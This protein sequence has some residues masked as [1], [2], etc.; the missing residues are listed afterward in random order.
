MED[1]ELEKR[2]IAKVQAQVASVV[3]ATFK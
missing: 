1:A 2:R 3:D